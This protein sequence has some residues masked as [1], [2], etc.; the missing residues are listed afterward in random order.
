MLCPF[1]CSSFLHL[2]KRQ[3]YLR[4]RPFLVC[5]RA[6]SNT[7]TRIPSSTAPRGVAVNSSLKPVPRLDRDL[8]YRRLRTAYELPLPRCA[9]F[10]QL[11]HKF[12]THGHRRLRRSWSVQRGDDLAL[13]VPQATI[14]ASSTAYPGEPRVASSDA[15]AISPLLAGNR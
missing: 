13:D 12:L 15:G 11:S 3:P 10:T 6:P 4:V 9:G 2:H 14:P 1:P 8:S 7:F 5:T